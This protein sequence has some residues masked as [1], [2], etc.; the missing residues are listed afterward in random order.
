MGQLAARLAPKPAILNRMDFLIVLCAKYLYLIIGLIAAIY[1]LTLPKKQKIQMAI[2]ATCTAIIA[3][4]LTKLGGALFYDPRPFVTQHIMP[5]Y[6][7]AADN[8]FPSDHTVLAATIAVAVYSGSKKLGLVLF[9]LAIVIGVS[10]VLA[11]IH[12]PIDILGSLIFAI[13]GGLAAYYLMPKIMVRVL[14]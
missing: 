8:G 11:H 1:W 7:H 4:V 2:F 9:G 5:L 6:P 14:K 10:R 12:S 13:A 3:F